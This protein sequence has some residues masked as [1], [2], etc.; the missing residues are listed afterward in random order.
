MEAEKPVR[1]LMRFSTLELSEPTPET[2]ATS[3]LKG[4]LAEI[5]TKIKYPGVR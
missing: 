5:C 4:I 3:M 2:N 1:L